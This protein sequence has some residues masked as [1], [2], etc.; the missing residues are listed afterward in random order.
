MIPPSP[1]PSLSSQLCSL[2]PSLAGPVL[3]FGVPTS[4]DPLSPPPHHLVH[5]SS[6]GPAA[7][8]PLPPPDALC[9]PPS[10]HHPPHHHRGGASQDLISAPPTARFPA[11]GPHPSAVPAPRS[12]PGTCVAPMTTKPAFTQSGEF[13]SVCDWYTCSVCNVVVAFLVIG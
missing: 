5:G 6:L 11:P 7:G 12:M 10:S 13:C 1:Y 2:S 9:Y 8:A 4:L 3:D